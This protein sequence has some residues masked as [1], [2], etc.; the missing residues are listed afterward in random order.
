MPESA[1]CV[2]NMSLYEKK[3]PQLNSL[4]DFISCREG[5]RHISYG[6]SGTSVIA[7]QTE[8]EGKLKMNRKPESHGIHNSHKEMTFERLI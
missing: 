8:R 7:K 2:L 5:Q 3:R 6:I 1:D 4:V